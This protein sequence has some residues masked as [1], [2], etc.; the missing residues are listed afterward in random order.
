MARK[1]KDPEALRNAITDAAEQIIVEEGFRAC[2][3]RAVT[4]KAGC[5]LGS[6]GYLFGGLDNVILQVNARTL[7][8]MGN[9]MFAEAEKSSGNHTRKLEA[10]A[11]GYFRYAR[12]HLNRWDALFALRWGAQEELPS[13]YLALRDSLVE[14][15]GTL[16]AADMPVSAQERSVFARTM[17]E[18]VHGIVVLG[19]DRRLGGSHEDVETRLRLLIR[20]M[21]V[22][23]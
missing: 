2:S 20:K 21:I 4:G 9:F 17:Y 16:F 5:A 14:R 19:L 7:V 1:G 11:L 10:L 3:A 15:I 8:D 22:S 6:L 13:D 23:E 18:A 12:D